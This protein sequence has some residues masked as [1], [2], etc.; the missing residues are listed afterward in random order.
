MHFG[1]DSSET[2]QNDAVDEVRVPDRESS[3]AAEGG[4]MG[5]IKKKEKMSSD[6]CSCGHAREA[7][8]HYR[9]G[10]ECSICDVTSCSAFTPVAVEEY[11][12]TS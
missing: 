5:I 3:D 11:T 6:M 2:D 4:A 8:E 9:R 7:H 1:A 12:K 10:T